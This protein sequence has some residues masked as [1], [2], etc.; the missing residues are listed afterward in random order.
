[1]N[2]H[3]TLECSTNSR[4]TM[5]STLTHEPIYVK[6]GFVLIL[7]SGLPRMEEKLHAKVRGT[8]D[9]SGLGLYGE[10]AFLYRVRSGVVHE[11][12]VPPAVT[13]PGQIR[14]T[15]VPDHREPGTV[16]GVSQGV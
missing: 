16:S 2:G 15:P 4:S 11:E 13:E 3:E 7:F 6:L 1:M 14:T 8:E 10:P 9:T 12:H 5:W